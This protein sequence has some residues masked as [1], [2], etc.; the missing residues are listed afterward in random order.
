MLA[1]R[2]AGSLLRDFFFPF[3]LHLTVVSWSRLWGPLFGS[4]TGG[5]WEAVIRLYSVIV[6]SAGLIRDK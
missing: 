3:F 4:L 2:S 1:P 6:L 5:N